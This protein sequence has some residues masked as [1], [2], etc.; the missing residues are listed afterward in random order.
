MTLH[1]LWA[2]PAREDI[3]RDC[4]H[5]LLPG[6]ALLLGGAA[7]RLLQPG[8]Q[9][10]PL[11]DSGIHLH[12]LAADCAELG[13]AI[14]PEVQATTPGSFVALVCSHARSVSWF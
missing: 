10:L 3:L 2:D 12:A 14:P 7:V 11:P 8:V 4:L 13:I 9:R 1:L 5:A 6:D